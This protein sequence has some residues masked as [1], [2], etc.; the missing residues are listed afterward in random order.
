MEVA[1]RQNLGNPMAGTGI[2]PGKA[3]LNMDLIDEFQRN[4][5]D[6]TMATHIYPG[7]SRDTSHNAMPG[8]LSFG[9]MGGRSA[10][11]E[12]GAPNE[13][14]IVGVSGMDYHDGRYLSLDAI[15]RGFYFQGVV[16]TPCTISADA[17]GTG[18]AGGGIT[19]GPNSGYAL[20]KAGVA[21]IINKSTYMFY[22]GDYVCR[23]LPN[24]KK[25]LPI[26]NPLARGG[27]PNTQYTWEV[28][29][30][31]YTDFTVHY[32]GAYRAMVNNASRGGI[33]DVAFE[34]FFETESTR[35][36][37]L[38]SNLQEEAAGHL[39]S[40]MGILMV[41]LEYLLEKGFIA[42]NP[43]GGV[44]AMDA[45][46]AAK[47]VAVLADALGFL[48]QGEGR[49]GHAAEMFRRMFHS[50]ILDDG[51]TAP[52]LQSLERE[53][54]DYVRLRKHLA[55][56]DSGRLVGNWHAKRSTIIGRVQNFCA[57]TETMHTLLGHFT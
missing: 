11:D 36:S 21:N 31:D 48:K 22:P 46:Q 37:Y 14:G 10:Y 20:I 32:D 54:K 23:R 35:N 9:L 4:A 17:D 19:S 1:S 29:P 53:H 12:T 3:F 40:K 45:G 44:G 18:T 52:N 7:G 24:P 16:S 26:I 30:F 51:K 8:D 6:K 5:E 33:A 56:F 15:E 43:A 49:T 57:P 28:C 42:V 34:R 50:E 2:I 55:T 27:T 39:F 25:G 47:S 13:V 41:G 38:L